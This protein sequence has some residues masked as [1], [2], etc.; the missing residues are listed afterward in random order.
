MRQNARDHL[1]KVF[2]EQDLALLKSE[3]QMIDLKKELDRSETQKKE[4]QIEL[5][6]SENEK[7][8]LKKDLVQ[9]EM[10]LQKMVS[11]C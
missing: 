5:E 2:V 11:Y 4:L 9:I 3:A 7:K 1:E 6:K 10:Q 8:D